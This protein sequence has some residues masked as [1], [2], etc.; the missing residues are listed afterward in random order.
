M[1]LQIV[2]ISLLALGALGKAAA[3][4]GATPRRA[5]T[6]V[7]AGSLALLAVGQVLSIPSLTAGV[8]RGLGIGVGKVFNGFVMSGLCALIVFFLLAEQ[9]SPARRRAVRAQVAILVGVVAAL[10]VLMLL[11][12]AASRGHTVSSPSV[13]LAPVAAFYVVGGAYFL[14]AYGLCA[15]WTWRYTRQASGALRLALGVVGLGL[16]GLAIT[17]ITRVVYVGVHYATD[18]VLAPLNSVNRIGSEVSTILLVVGLFVLGVA[19]IVPVALL[20][21]RRQRQS[22]KLLPLWHLLTGLY[23][24]IVLPVRG[25]GGTNTFARRVL[26]CRDGLLRLTPTLAAIAGDADLAAADAAHLASWVR[27]AARREHEAEPPRV[28]PAPSTTMVAAPATD[29]LDGDADRLVA[30]SVRLEELP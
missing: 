30:I 8:D 11:T 27:E 28:D 22:R 24:E 1:A 6:A 18:V 13:S 25:A 29:T 26:E 16:V 23:P 20:Q 4:L 19:Q 17:S 5:A 9:G 12:P 15:A 14:Y 7:L 21:A 3:L 2:L 10:L